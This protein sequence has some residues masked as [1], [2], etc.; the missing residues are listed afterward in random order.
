MVADLRRWFD[1]MEERHR[2]AYR[3]FKEEQTGH[4]T[5]VQKVEDVLEAQKILQHI[6]QGVQEQAHRQIAS[7][8]TKCL[9]GVFDRPYEFKILFERKRGK[10]EAKLVLCREGVELTNPK[11]EAGGGVLDVA[12]LALR[13]AKLVLERPRRRRVLVLD[14]PFRCVDEEN[15]TRVREL[16]LVLAREMKVQF[17]IATHN[18]G[19]RAGKVIQIG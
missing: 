4:T 17:I 8:V 6:A 12:A 9:Q 5:A 3:R 1:M 13:L 15:S 19:L 10:T 11:D 7:V 14:E 18:E 2:T 16:L